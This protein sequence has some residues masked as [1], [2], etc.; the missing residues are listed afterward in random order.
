MRI[1]ILATG[2]VAFLA[3]CTTTGEN[4]F[5]SGSDSTDDGGGTADGGTDDGSGIDGGALPPGTASPGPTTT[6]FR[7]EARNAENGNGFAEGFTYNAADDTFTVD[8]LAFDGDNTY[9]R[10]DV[11]GSLGPYAVYEADAT[12][13]DTFDGQLIDQFN[14]RALYGVS[15]SGDTEFAI[16]RTGAYTGYGF[17]GF[18]Y[19]RNTGVTLPENG[20]AIY[21]GDYAGLR[22]FDG[23]GGLQYTTGDM[24]IGI[25]FG[26]F[27]DGDGVYGSVT[28]RVIFDQNGNDVTDAVLASINAEYSSSLTS[29]PILGFLVGPG[30]MD[31]N[32]ELTGDVLSSFVADDGTVINFE[33]GNFYAMVAGDAADEIVGIVVV[34]GDIGDITARETGG[35]IVYN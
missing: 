17:G 1:S 28:N 18:I 6:I 23:T 32:G 14:Y 22:D 25:D 4:P 20:Q 11:V 16:V 12:V 10:D 29:L 27:N 13:T 3:A 26:D 31:D 21:R 34:E 24:E 15:T 7:R 35:F 5:D 30:V 2:L 33:T 19:Q 8:G 9:A